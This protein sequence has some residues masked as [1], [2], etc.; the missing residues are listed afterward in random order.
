[1]DNQFISY[2][3][4]TD[5]GDLHS[6]FLID[7][8]RAAEA[9]EPRSYLVTLEQVKYMEFSCD[10]FIFANICVLDRRYYTNIA[11]D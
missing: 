2:I 8:S 11:S 10:S 7:V 5:I 1:M 9:A 6:T 4:G 3:N